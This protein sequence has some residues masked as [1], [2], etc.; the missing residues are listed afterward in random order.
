[1]SWR[2]VVVSSRCKL[3]YKLGYMIC[4]GEKTKKIHLSEI[5][6]LIIETPAV[7]LTAVLVSELVKNKINIVFCDEKHNP[8]SQILPFYGCH[9]CSGK[10]KNQLVWTDDIK[11]EVWA[12]IIKYKILQQASLMLL[13]GS[14]RAEMLFEYISQV[15]SG[16]ISNREGHAAKVYFNDVFGQEFSRSDNCFINSA[17]NYGYALLLSAFNREIVLCGYDTR[18]GLFH[19]NEFNYFN[20]SSDLMEPFRP[21]VDRMVYELHGTEFC[22]EH[23][24]IMQNVFNVK[25]KIAGKERTVNDAVSEYVK[26]VFDA[27]NQCDVSLIKNYEL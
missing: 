12:Q 1:M 10:I 17:L 23:K 21:I 19:R 16:D 4:R 20:L 26:S 27:L 15:Q 3:E 2:T 9:D 6:S 5:S 7:A 13:A 24:R 11:S 18:L 25:V 22:P 14:S 8:S